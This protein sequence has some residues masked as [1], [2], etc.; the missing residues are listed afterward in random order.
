MSFIPENR[1]MRFK[2][3]KTYYYINYVVLSRIMVDVFDVKN[4][5][6]NILIHSCLNKKE[7]IFETN[8]FYP[9]LHLRSY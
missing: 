1:Y 3:I 4:L 9:I 5:F 6:F 7:I 8:D 2:Y